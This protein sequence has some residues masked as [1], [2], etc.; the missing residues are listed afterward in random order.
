VV[1]TARAERDDP[2]AAFESPGGHGR[3]PGLGERQALPVSP[4]SPLIR[5]RA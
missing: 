2:C 3:A 1:R 4:R 5:D